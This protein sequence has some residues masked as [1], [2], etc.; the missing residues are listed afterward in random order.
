MHANVNRFQNIRKIGIRVFPYGRTG[1]L[2]MCCTWATYWA[3]HG[4]PMEFLQ[5]K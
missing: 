3:V 1:E 2:P 5:C 4:L